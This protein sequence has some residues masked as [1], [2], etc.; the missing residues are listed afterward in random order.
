MSWKLLKTPCETSSLLHALRA[1]YCYC[2]GSARGGGG[3][4]SGIPIHLKTWTHGT[5]SRIYPQNHAKYQNLERHSLLY[6]HRVKI[7]CT[8]FKTPLYTMYLKTLVDPDF[9]LASLLYDSLTFQKANCTDKFDIRF[10]QKTKWMYL[11]KWLTWLW[12]PLSVTWYW[13]TKLQTNDL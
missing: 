3:G 9:C 12:F 4:V 10:P 13:H 1:I 2:S 7:L 5:I 8:Q 11:L 6:N